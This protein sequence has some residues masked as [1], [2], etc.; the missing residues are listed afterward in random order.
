MEGL[1]QWADA[2]VTCLAL[3]RAAIAAQHPRWSAAQI[4]ARLRRELDAARRAELA[5]YRRNG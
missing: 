3:R 1:R 2:T 5:A 4:E